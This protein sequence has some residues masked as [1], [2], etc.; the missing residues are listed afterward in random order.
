[1]LHLLSLK[2]EFLKVSLFQI[3]KSILPQLFNNLE[4]ITQKFVSSIFNINNSNETDQ[5]KILDFLC[6]MQKTNLIRK[7]YTLIHLQLWNLNLYKDIVPTW[8][9]WIT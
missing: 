7:K 5:L 8:L 1:M 9:F 2:M 6:T 3:D 4:M